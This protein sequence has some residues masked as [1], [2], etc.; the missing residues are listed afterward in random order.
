MPPFLLISIGLWCELLK[1]LYFITDQ[2]VVKQLNSQQTSSMWCHE[3]METF[4]ALL[5][6]HAGFFYAMC[7]TSK[8]EAF[9]QTE[10][11]IQVEMHYLDLC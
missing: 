11:N 5:F 1:L 6:V 10:V 7:S 9:C 4:T 2:A 8:Q 3:H